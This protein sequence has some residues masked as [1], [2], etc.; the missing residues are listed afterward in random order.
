[1]RS[2]PDIKSSKL[3]LVKKADKKEPVKPAKTA[4]NFFSKVAESKPT[5]PAINVKE[6]EFTSSTTASASSTSKPTAQSKKKNPLAAAFA[7]QSK[8]PKKSKVVISNVEEEKNVPESNQLEE[9]EEDRKEK[10]RKQ[11]ELKNIFN[12]DD[13]VMSKLK[14]LFYLKLC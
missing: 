12:D 13:A 14:F 11:E 2:R 6:S 10:A 3:D 8:L 5:K 4:A 7:I 1:L 9:T